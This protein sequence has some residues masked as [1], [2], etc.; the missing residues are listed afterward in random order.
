[1][2]QPYEAMAERLVRTS[3]NGPSQ[4]RADRVRYL[5]EQTGAD[6]VV[7]FCHWG[8]RQTAGAAQLIRRELE[9]AGYPT[10]V[11]D[12]DGCDR[13]NNMTGQLSTRFE[14]FLE[15]LRSRRATGAPTRP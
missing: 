9:A 2:R 5:A 10:L 15:L 14:A 3:F 8:C 11:L 4:R 1:M 13:K 12:G 6:G 7:V